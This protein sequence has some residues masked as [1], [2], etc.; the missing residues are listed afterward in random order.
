MGQKAPKATVGEKFPIPLFCRPIHVSRVE[1]GLAFLRKTKL[2][3]VF[4]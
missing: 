1:V 3:V 2:L 4:A